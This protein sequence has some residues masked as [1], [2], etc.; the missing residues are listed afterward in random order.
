MSEVMQLSYEELEQ[1]KM[2]LVK[3]QKFELAAR[4]REIQ[5]SLGN[6]KTEDAEFE[7]LDNPQNH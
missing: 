4:V 3:H 6:I 1:I 7:I 2:I 5:R